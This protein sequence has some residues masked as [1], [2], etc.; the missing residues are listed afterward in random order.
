MVEA[1]T[2]TDPGLD[3]GLDSGAAVLAAARSHRRAAD[4]HEA[5][6]LR[7]AA[8]GRFFEVGEQVDSLA[9]TS[10]IRGSLDLA[11]AL[12]LEDAV[13]AGAR[14]LGELGHPESLNA[15]RAMALGVLARGQATLDLSQYANRQR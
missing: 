11:D 13:A 14:A 6:L 9:G 10:P 2:D 15:R 5:E 7:A 3:S 4:A 1:A 8:D 12:D